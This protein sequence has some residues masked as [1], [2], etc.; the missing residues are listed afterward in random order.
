MT[1]PP[2]FRTPLAGPPADALSLRTS[3]SIH[4]SLVSDAPPPPEPPEPPPPP[5]SLPAARAL[6]SARDRAAGALVSMLDGEES[7]D[8]ARV[9]C[10]VAI[11]VLG[12]PVR[13]HKRKENRS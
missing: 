6:A 3:S 1:N 7:C 2:A 4:G 11:L 9:A 8:L 5:K 13:P 12:A 10:A